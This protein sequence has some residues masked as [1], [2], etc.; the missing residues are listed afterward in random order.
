MPVARSRNGVV[1]KGD[2]DEW[3]AGL[4]VSQVRV[5]RP[6]DKLEDVVAFYSGC[7]GPAGAV[8]FHWARG[9]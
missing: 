3:P 2:A 1:L 9:I 5:A 4:M 6:T 7:L 8:P